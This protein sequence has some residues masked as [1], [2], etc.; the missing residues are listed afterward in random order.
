MSQEYNTSPHILFRGISSASLA[1]NILYFTFDSFVHWKVSQVFTS[2]R[3][4]F[5]MTVNH[6]R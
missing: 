6:K 2:L 1:V 5:L 3:T 4:E